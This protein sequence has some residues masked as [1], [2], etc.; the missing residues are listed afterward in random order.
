[1]PTCQT[2]STWNPDGQTTC[3]N[4]GASLPQTGPDV[5]PPY[6]SAPQQTPAYGA[7]PMFGQSATSADV[8]EAQK[9]ARKAMIAAVVGIFCFGFIL[10]VLAYRWAREAKATLDAAGAAQGHGLAVA[11]MVLG[12]VDVVLWLAGLLARVMLR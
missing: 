3:G 4:C 12:A 2:C 6:S 11:A 5:P 1:M 9:Q 8:A 10:G 7:P